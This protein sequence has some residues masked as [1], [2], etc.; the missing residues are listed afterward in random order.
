MQKI[1]NLFS[2]LS[3]VGILVLFVLHFNSRS[4]GKSE[5]KG[6]VAA[7]KRHSDSGSVKLAYI[8]LDTI[9]EYYIYFQQKNK[10]L[11]NEK[12]QMESEI[13]TEIRKL[14]NDRA[15]FL[16]KGESITQVEADQF[17][18]QFQTRYQ[19]LSERRENLLN[20]HVANQTRAY[21][22][23]QQ[24]IN[25][26]L[27]VYNETAGYQFIFSVGAGNL[28][29]YYQDPSLNITREVLDGLNAEFEKK[30]K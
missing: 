1:F 3:I 20:R 26:F 2:A 5:K 4:S 30:D 8:D 21:D 12:K 25:A 29:V 13:E 9:Q 18:Q 28:S 16:K 22:D 19:Q 7:V 27:K 6:I 24:K 17:Q 15:N 14:E 11:E 10:E 23:I